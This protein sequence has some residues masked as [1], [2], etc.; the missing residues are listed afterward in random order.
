MP[1]QKPCEPGATAVITAGESSYRL[2]T[3]GSGVSR[4][5]VPTAYLENA[6]QAPA[7]GKL[8]R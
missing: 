5:Q 2:T 1:G 3:R 4:T 6:D 7:D 8:V